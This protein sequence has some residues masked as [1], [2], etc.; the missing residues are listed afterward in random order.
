MLARPRLFTLGAFSEEGPS[1]AMKAGSSFK[2]ELF[3][4]G[5]SSSAER[6][7]SRLE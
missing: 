1:N 2:T 5:Y 6:S 4:A 7:R 3:G